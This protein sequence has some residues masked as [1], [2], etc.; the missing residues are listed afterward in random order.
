MDEKKKYM[1]VAIFMGSPSDLPTVQPAWKF[2]T[3]LGADAWMH[4]LS[5]HRTPKELR[6][7]LLLIEASV[8]VAC[9]G[10]S[11][12][13]A[14]YVSALKPRRPVIALPR[15]SGLLGPGLDALLSM[16]Q[17]PNGVPSACIGVDCG[18]NAGILAAQ[19][20]AARDDARGA[21]AF[22]DL[23]EA[24][25]AERAASVSKAN[26]E[27]LEQQELWRRNSWGTSQLDPGLTGGG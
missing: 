14:G 1:D 9:A 5:V 10:G 16:V 3:D 21:P 13:L 18:L 4:I 7:T 17:M 20:L 6:E 15:S 24:D 8:Y 27:I 25:R 23:L 11:A 2:L 26:R 19:I 22:G 12:H